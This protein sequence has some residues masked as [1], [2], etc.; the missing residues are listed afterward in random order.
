MIRLPAWTAAAGAI[1][2]ALAG[3]ALLGSAPADAAGAAPAGEALFRQRCQVCHSAVAAKPSTVGP[4][5]A[6]VVGRKAGATAFAYSP[7]LKASKFNWDRASLDRFLTAPTKMVPGTRMVIS[8]TDKA[9]RSALIEY[10][11]GTKKP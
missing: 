10:L 9:Q 4:N 1:P 7:A 5:L 3:L 6:G 8:V 11:A 2:L